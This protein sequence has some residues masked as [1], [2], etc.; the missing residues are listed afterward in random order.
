MADELKMDPARIARLRDPARYALVDPLRV[1][2]A[3]APLGDGPIVDVGAGVGFVSLP[4]ARHFPERRIV[5]ADILAG[6]LE[7]LDEAAAA[8]G[9][10]NLESALMPGPDALPLDAD[11]AS[12]LIM[13]QVHHELDDP[14][15]LLKECRRVLAPGAP[16]VIV[17]W[18]NEDLPDMPKGGRRV[19]PEKIAADLADAGF[20]D[21]TAHDLYRVHSVLV[22]TTP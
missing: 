17:D 21:P 13:L 6:M 7:L 10:G 22:A 11:G 8:E 12:F 20:A 9:L 14:V 19:A 3:A 4:L 18:K 15:G 2:A 1:L 16:V 5:A